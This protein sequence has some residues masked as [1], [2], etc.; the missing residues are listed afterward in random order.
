[1][2]LSPEIRNIRRADT[3]HLYPIASDTIALVL[4]RIPESLLAA[5]TDS[6]ATVD[7]NYDHKEKRGTEIK[8]S[9]VPSDNCTYKQTNTT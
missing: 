6:D 2:P 4:T 7:E 8:Y 1:M 5:S 9:I 3:R